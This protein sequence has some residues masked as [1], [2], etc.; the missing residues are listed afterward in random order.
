[1]TTTV[2]LSTRRR[3]QVGRIPKAYRFRRVG[4]VLIRKG[5]SR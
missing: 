5:P 4:E 1:M 3:G 2:G